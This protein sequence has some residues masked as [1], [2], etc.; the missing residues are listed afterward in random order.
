MDGNNYKPVY[1]GD[2]NGEGQSTAEILE[3]I[4][5]RFNL[6]HPDD[7]RGHSLSVSD[8]VVLR[9]DGRDQ[10]YFVESYGF[11]EVPEFFAA[12]PLEKVEELMEVIRTTLI[13]PKWVI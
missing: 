3:S 1:Q 4:Y 9:E 7:F 10:T 5:K 2:L 11:M 13:S 8:I 12:N 6:H